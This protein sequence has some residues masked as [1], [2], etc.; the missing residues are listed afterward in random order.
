MAGRQRG[1]RALLVIDVQKDFCEG[2]SLAVEGGDAVAKRICNDIDSDQYDVVVVTQDW[3]IDPG[4][5]FDEW[6]VHCKA[7]QQGAELH[8]AAAAF[9][10]SAKATYFRKGMHAAAYSGFES[11]MVRRGSDGEEVTDTPLLDVLRLQGITEVDVCG[12][13]TDYCV[14]ATVVDAVKSGFETTVLLDFCAAVSP[15]TERAA[16]QEM[17]NVGAIM[18]R[19]LATDPHVSLDID[20]LMS[21]GSRISML[22][23]FDV[24]LAAIT[25]VSTSSQAA[26]PQRLCG[27]WMPIAR[28]RCVLPSGHDRRTTHCRSRI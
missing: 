17:R 2:G 23:A 24:A 18:Q 6:P 27:R 14:K 16:I 20:E 4:E 26:K 13:A 12:L 3:H 19:E 28:A 10:D 8:P 1:N 7:G 25:G 5:H 15:E 11:F 22:D 21:A 9:A